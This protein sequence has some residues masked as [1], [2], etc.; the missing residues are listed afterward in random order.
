MTTSRRTQTYNNKTLWNV[1]RGADG[2]VRRV[3]DVV[4]FP[5][6]VRPHG[7]AGA[8]KH[9]WAGRMWEEQ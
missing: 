5:L 8:V 4:Q 6:T 3:V 9:A 2:D 1:V 7:L